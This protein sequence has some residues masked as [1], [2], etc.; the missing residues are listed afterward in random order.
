MTPRDW[1]A[2]MLLDYAHPET[3]TERDRDA[4]LRWRL[5]EYASWLRAHVSRET[6]RSNRREI[7]ERVDWFRQERGALYRKRYAHCHCDRCRRPGA[8]PFFE[9]V[10]RELQ[11]IEAAIHARIAQR[12]SDVITTGPEGDPG[13]SRGHPHGRDRAG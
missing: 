10:Y 2:S 6:L 12:G 3:W 9:K 1:C 11:G 5:S 8:S 4:Y 13:R 7:R